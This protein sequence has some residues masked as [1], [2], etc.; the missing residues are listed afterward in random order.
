MRTSQTVTQ[1]QWSLNYQILKGIYLSCI[2]T[3]IEFQEIDVRSNMEDVSSSSLELISAQIRKALIEIDGDSVYINKP[4]TKPL[5][6]TVEFVPNSN[7]VIMRFH[8]IN[9]RSGQ[10]STNKKA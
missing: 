10:R 6:I 7:T 5:N 8:W 4:Q 2:L 1:K 3:F 9:V